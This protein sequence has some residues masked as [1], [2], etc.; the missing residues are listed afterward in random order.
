M[1]DFEE[2]LD[3][4]IHLDFKKIA[5]EVDTLIIKKASGGLAQL[6]RPGYDKGNLVYGTEQKPVDILEEFTK[7]P[8]EARGIK[9]TEEAKALAEDKERW[10]DVLKYD[11]DNPVNFNSRD[12]L[13][14]FRRQ[15]PKKIQK[16]LD[17]TLVQLS[18]MYPDKK[19]ETMNEV[20]ELINKASVEGKLKGEI[21]GSAITLTRV[22]DAVR[23][24]TKIKIK[25]PILNVRGDIDKDRYDISKD[26]K[27]GNVDLGY[28]TT[29]DKGKQTGS[30]Y[31]LD[32]PFN[33]KNLESNIGLRRS[34]NKYN[35]SDLLSLDSTYNTGNLTAALA[36]DIEKDKFGTTSRLEPSLKYDIPTDYGT[37]SASASKNI[38]EGGDADA[39]LS[40]T[41]GDTGH[42]SDEDQFWRI[43]AELDPIEGKK[44]AF[45]GFKSKFAKGGVAGLLGE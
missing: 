26:L 31:S 38:I 37:L 32:V 25:S 42:P 1:K 14:V 43:S 29:F 36:A 20:K 39:N 17:T 12:Y 33:L 40:Y 27:L 9:A 2:G 44:K 8:A 13:S 34:E 41:Y 18:L 22:F 16:L 45:I 6:A 4:A 15:A 11:S 24:S 5:D 21:L 3:E 30:T 19:P 35:T 23:D 7:Y 28:Q 10:Q